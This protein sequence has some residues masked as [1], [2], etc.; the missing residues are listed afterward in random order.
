VHI[1]A[2]DSYSNLRGTRRRQRIVNGRASHRSRRARGSAM[3]E[4][5]FRTCGDPYEGRARRDA[6]ECS[7]CLEIE[8]DPSVGPAYTNWL[9]ASARAIEKLRCWPTKVAASPVFAFPSSTGNI[10][11]YCR[12]ARSPHTTRPVSMIPSAVRWRSR[13]GP[14]GHRRGL[15]A[16]RRTGP[17]AES[18]PSSQPNRHGRQAEPIQATHQRILPMPCRGP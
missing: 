13:S 2:T 4:A 6:S 17:I 9:G 11:R 10:R 16:S 3:S 14:C 12:Q 7:P 1:D 15:L 18:M 8:A 5:R